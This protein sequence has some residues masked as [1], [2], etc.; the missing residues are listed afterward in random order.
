MVAR[1]EKNKLS[2]NLTKMLEQNTSMLTGLQTE[3]EK[4]KALEREKLRMESDLRDLVK[5][6]AK[7]TNE[8]NSAITDRDNT[9]RYLSAIEREFNWLKK[10]T[11]EEQD[12][13]LKLER[14]RNKLE[15]E[16]VNNTHKHR[17]QANQ[18]SELKNLQHNA[19][20]INKDLMQKVKR[21]SEMI[22]KQ[23]SEIESLNIKLRE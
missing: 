6:K 19:D 16:Q 18:I 17:M 20:L 7:L 21:L 15:N 14:D 2:D 8:R 5:A 23:Q 3:Q 10:K 9:K 11:E 22:G 4:T 13:I 12:N 1:E